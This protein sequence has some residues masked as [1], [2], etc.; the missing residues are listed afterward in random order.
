MLQRWDL[1]EIVGL[2]VQVKVFPRLF[3]AL[4]LCHC[5]LHAAPFWIAIRGD[6]KEG[7]D[8]GGRAGCVESVRVRV[9]V[10]VRAG[11]REGGGGGGALLSFMES[12]SSSRA[13]DA[14]KIVAATFAAVLICASL[15]S[16]PVRARDLVVPCVVERDRQIERS[17][18]QDEHLRRC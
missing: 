17:V 3:R 18:E 14:T 9:R 8:A 16:G 2:R 10:R 6:A 1:P 13:C 12:K 11:G 7:S 5:H 4:A 15:E